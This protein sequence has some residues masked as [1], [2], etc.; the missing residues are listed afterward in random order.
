ML[1][2]PCLVVLIATAHA[3][4]NCPWS[5]DLTDLDTDCVCSY[6]THQKLSI[7]C[8]PVNF[9]RLLKALNSA[10]NVPIDL[11]FIDNTTVSQLPDGIFSRLNIQSLQF[12][13][14]KVRNISDKAFIGLER[15]LTTL[16]LAN[17]ELTEIPIRAIQR[18]TSLKNLDLS[19]NKI[20]EVPAD[21]FVNLP[22]STLRLADNQVSIAPDAFNG[23]EGTL[24]NLNLKN[25]GQD[26]IPKAVT[27]LLTL[28]FLDLAQNKIGQIEPGQLATMNT[29]TALNL[30]RNRILRIDADSFRGINDTLSSLS[31][32]NNL[33]VEFPAEAM[34]TLTEL[35]VLDLGFNGI[36]YI[37]EKAFS[38][39]PLLTLLALDGNPMSSIPIEPFQH[40]KSTLRGLSIGGPYLE[41]D[42][43]IRWIAEWIRS[44]DLQVTSRERT[45]QYCGKPEHL[46]RKQFGQIEL[47]DFV[48]DG[49][50]STTTVVSPQSTSAT[51]TSTT[52][53]T[54][55]TTQAPAAQFEGNDLSSSSTVQSID[56]T[57]QLPQRGTKFAPRTRP[58][59]NSRGVKTNISQPPPATSKQIAKP[60]VKNLMAL[61][62]DSSIKLE[63]SVDPSNS[64]GFQ[65]LY[66]IFGDRLYRKGPALGPDQRGYLLQNLPSGDCI[67]VCVI[68]IQE[69]NDLTVDN[70]PMNQCRELK[71]ERYGIASL[72]KVIIIASAILSAVIIIGVCAILC[73]M[74]RKHKKQDSL[75]KQRISTGVVPVLKPDMN[76]W[77]T[78]SVYSSRSIPR[79]RMY[80]LDGQTNSSY[81]DDARSHVSHSYIPNGYGT[82]PRGPTAERAFSQM[83]QHNSR[84]YKSNGNLSTM[85]NDLRKSQQSLSAVS[86]A[87]VNSPKKHKRSNSHGRLTSASSTHSLTE[88]D[89]DWNG[90]SENNWKDNEVDIYVGHNHRYR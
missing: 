48:C 60:I 7:Q 56:T 19:T 32:L 13:R 42:C 51:S 33:L 14:A 24:K 88:Y 39:N 10:Q 68:T 15:S 12:S 66:R 36:R 53:T 41:C 47:S 76:E 86:A 40:L 64:Q 18:L 79:A 82:K 1:W 22:L 26:V 77:E 17:N 27:R 73:C 43:R 35:R 21:A 55:T 59:S 2:L 61:R 54:T 63:W 81:I 37:P 4:A 87:Y 30:E 50:V 65:I 83:S 84:L 5:R 72:D 6:N 52:T 34:R 49:P 45:P 28:T 11:L 71:S 69:A 31:L 25:T 23:L 58:A 85:A 46:K 44:T 67:V 70:V 29:L 75:M 38:T 74:R 80:H 89:S 8:S 57:E 16:N 62:K 20:A 90:R 3:Q 9:T 78:M